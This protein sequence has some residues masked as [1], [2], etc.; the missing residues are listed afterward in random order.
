MLSCFHTLESA[1][2]DQS[3]RKRKLDDD[4]SDGEEKS[5]S[6]TGSEL[7]SD[8]ADQSLVCLQCPM[9]LEYTGRILG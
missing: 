6:Y 9:G 3:K 5:E 1:S 4:Y 8:V 7:L 2:H